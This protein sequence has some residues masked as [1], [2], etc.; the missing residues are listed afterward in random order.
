[1]NEEYKNPMNKMGNT[2]N[3]APSIRLLLDMG[4]LAAFFITYRIYD[5]M[6]A[7]G[8]LIVCTTL[9]LAYIY[10]KERKLAPMPLVTG[11]MVTFFGALTLLLHDEQFIKMKPTIVNLLFA[12][13]LLGGLIFKKPM[14]KW[15][16]GYALQME[17]RGWW[18]LS[19]R[20]GLFFVFLAGL[21]EFIWRS[22]PT[23]FW[24]N[25]KVFG[26]LSCTIVFTLFQLPLMKRYL[27]EPVDST[28]E[29]SQ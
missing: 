22:F 10:F 28:T 5:L 24:V 2:E 13:I 1:M 12:S 29:K 8:A 16:L 23:D 19:L 18:L 26:M 21:N 6:I 14:L 9:S 15:A 20:W 27:I 3:I 4:P 25:F 17:E 7:T 11:V